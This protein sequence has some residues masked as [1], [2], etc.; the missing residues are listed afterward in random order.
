MRPAWTAGHAG[1]EWR[2]RRSRSTWI[3]CSRRAP[4]PVTPWGWTRHLPRHGRGLP[5]GGAC[6]SSSPRA[7]R[8]HVALDASGVSPRVRRTRPPQSA[9]DRRPAHAVRPPARASP[10]ADRPSRVVRPIARRPLRR[11]TGRRR[12]RHDEGRRAPRPEEAWSLPP[13]GRAGAAAP[14]PH[15]P[16]LAGPT[17]RGAGPRL[18][19]PA[20]S[21]RGVASQSAD[22][23]CHDPR[24]RPERR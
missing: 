3:A 21:R 4:S 24:A 6:P 11:V 13:G 20:S 7:A 19:T 18:M 16:R 9:G 22:P 17:R 14:T 5:G 8:P 23:S 10:A 2:T 1:A 12:G 15:A